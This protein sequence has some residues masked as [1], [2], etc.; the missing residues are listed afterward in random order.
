[1]AHTQRLAAS[2]RRGGGRAAGTQFTCFTGTNVPI[3]TLL[4]QWIHGGAVYECVKGARVMVREGYAEGV[5]RKLGVLHGCLLQRDG[6]RAVG[7]LDHRIREVR[8]RRN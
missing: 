7:M 5:G 2:C 6:S 8:C 4:R 1:M 3:L